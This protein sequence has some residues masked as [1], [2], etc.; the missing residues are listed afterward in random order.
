MENFRL[1]VLVRIKYINSWHYWLIH[2]RKLHVEHAPASPRR[3]ARIGIFTS[4]FSVFSEIPLSSTSRGDI[5][6]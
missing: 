5:G 4:N 1:D 3:V 2:L 6:N